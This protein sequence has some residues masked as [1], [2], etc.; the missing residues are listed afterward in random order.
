M[1]QGSFQTQLCAGLQIMHLTFYSAP[2]KKRLTNN[3]RENGH[4]LGHKLA[5]TVKLHK[6]LYIVILIDYVCV[7]F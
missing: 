1:K 4:C 3:E 6:R 2:L 7:Q 5:L